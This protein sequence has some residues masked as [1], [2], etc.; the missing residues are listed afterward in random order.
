MGGGVRINATGLYAA[1]ASKVVSK[2]LQVMLQ[3]PLLSDVLT[4]VAIL[5]AGRK[6][7]SKKGD[8][9]Q[10]AQLPRHPNSWLP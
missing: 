6:N 5:A 7:P 1:H 4:H 9:M 2:W 8:R 3:E 10:A